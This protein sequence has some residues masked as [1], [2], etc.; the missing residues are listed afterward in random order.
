MQMLSRIFNLNISNS[1]P[2]ISRHGRVLLVFIT[3]GFHRVLKKIHLRSISPYKLPEEPSILFCDDAKITLN[4]SLNIPSL[5]QP[6]TEIVFT[7]KNT[8]K[9]TNEAGVNGL[10][11]FDYIDAIR[12]FITLAM[13]E[14]VTV[15]NVRA[16]PKG[17]KNLVHVLYMPID[18]DLDYISDKSSIHDICFLHFPKEKT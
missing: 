1:K 8:I 4:A 9:I 10:F 18:I 7:E 11:F 16:M 15:Q 5:M 2:M 3:K 12:K 13:R 6:P 14:N 17:S